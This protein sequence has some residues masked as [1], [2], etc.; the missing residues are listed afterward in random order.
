VASYASWCAACALSPPGTRRPSAWA[1]TSGE[2]VATGSRRFP[3]LDYYG[4]AAGARK[5]CRTR[6]LASDK[7]E[8]AG[9]VTD[10]RGLNP[11]NRGFF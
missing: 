2:A 4:H 10:E 9:F 7:S 1:S 3:R 11:K 6:T 5:S 8:W